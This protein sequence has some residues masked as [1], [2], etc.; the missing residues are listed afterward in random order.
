MLRRIGARVRRWVAQ[1]DDEDLAMFAGVVVLTPIL[2]LA[3]AVALNV[4]E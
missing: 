1:Q 2:M 4:V 3:M